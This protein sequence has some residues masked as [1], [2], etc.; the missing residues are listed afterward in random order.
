MSVLFYRRP[1]YVQRAPGYLNDSDCQKYV[2][3]TKC[4]KHRPPPELSFDRIINNQTLPVSPVLLVPFRYRADVFMSQP[5]TLGDFMDYMIYVAQD[6]EQL[7]FFIWF[8]DF[9]NRYDTLPPSDKALSP[10]WKYDSIE[11]PSGPAAAQSPDEKWDE[12]AVKVNEA[13]DSSLAPASVQQEE[14]VSQPDGDDQNWPLKP[15]PDTAGDDEFTRFVQGSVAAQQNR[16]SSQ[17]LA[18]VAHA[19]AGLK[20]QGCE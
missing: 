20:W 6:A 18:S 8:R 2:E 5:C 3:R 19:Q 9:V 16:S 7:Q 15:P 10:E 11:N 4:S 13:A 12:I 14:Q 17:T 1:D